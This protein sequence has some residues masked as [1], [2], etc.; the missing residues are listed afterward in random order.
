[1]KGYRFPY[2]DLMAH[3]RREKAKRLARE[4]GVELVEGPKAVTGS[5]VSLATC[6]GCGEPLVR[7]GARGAWAHT[8]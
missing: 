7:K 1:M 8:S 4:A 3:A 6:S 5:V 2:A